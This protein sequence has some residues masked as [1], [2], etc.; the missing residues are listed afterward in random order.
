MK[1]CIVTGSQCSVNILCW[2]DSSVLYYNLSFIYA[3]F[4]LTALD[5]FGFSESKGSP[6][7]SKAQDLLFLV[8]CYSFWTSFLRSNHPYDYTGDFRWYPCTVLFLALQCYV[9][10]Q[11]NRSKIIQDRFKIWL[12]V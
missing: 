7:S 8:I 2:S 1:Q 11:E 6:S 9:I 12:F 10:G 5:E 4:T 3:A